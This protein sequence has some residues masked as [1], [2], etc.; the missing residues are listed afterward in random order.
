MS[1]FDKIKAKLSSLASRPRQDDIQIQFE[2]MDPAALASL[3]A[4]KAN[5]PYGPL[6]RL[7]NAAR[8]KEAIYA[9]VPEELRA[10]P[11]E[12][13]YANVPE[14]LRANPRGNAKAVEVEKHGS[15]ARTG[16]APQGSQGVGKTN[17]AQRDVFNQN[18]RLGAVDVTN[19]LTARLQEKKFGLKEAPKL[20]VVGARK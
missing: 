1:F 10:R 17:G 14:E 20:G 3:T 19:E 16:R 11:K 2:P 6:P 9:N 5:N 8:P 13:I 15:P 7:D 18:A 12:A 4:P